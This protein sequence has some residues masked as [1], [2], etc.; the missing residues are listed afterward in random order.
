MV[1][2]GEAGA[3]I[4][5]TRVASL[6]LSGLSVATITPLRANYAFATPG[7]QGTPR[8][9]G[10][11]RVV[12]Y[13]AGDPFPVI[14]RRRDPSRTRP[15]VHCARRR[16][17]WSVPC[18]RRQGQLVPAPEPFLSKNLF[19]IGFYRNAPMR[20]DAAQI[21]RIE[22]DSRALVKSPVELAIHDHIA[23]RAV[24]V[25]CGGLERLAVDH[26][27]RRAK[28]C[29]HSLQVAEVGGAGIGI[30]PPNCS[31]LALTV[32]KVIS[33]GA[34]PFSGE[35]LGSNRWLSRKWPK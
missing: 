29:F 22:H 2:A 8:K 17:R 1:A 24:L 4:F 5:Q 18:P 12:P 10:M 3:G 23:K 16:R 19:P 27:D 11:T 28:S 7:T 32:P 34:C 25:G 21:E 15:L 35:K 14:Q 20:G 13:L 26:R 9:G 6:R 30:L 31:E 33:R